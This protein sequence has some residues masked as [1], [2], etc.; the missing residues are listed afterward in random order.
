M[1]TSIDNSVLAGELLGLH[2]KHLKKRFNDGDIT[3]AELTVALKTMET[4][5]VEMRVTPTNAL[6]QLKGAITDHLPF[7]GDEGKTTYQ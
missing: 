3:A 5:G 7:A 2:L 4:M 6:G 1:S